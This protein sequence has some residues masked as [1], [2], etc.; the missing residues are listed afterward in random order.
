MI[1]S[2]FRPFLGAAGAALLF[3]TIAGCDSA[4]GPDTADPGINPDGRSSVT[5]QGGD[6]HQFIGGSFFATSADA[7]D[8]SPGVGLALY[9]VVAQDTSIVFFVSE[10]SNTR[11]SR[12]TY[13]IVLP[14]TTGSN[15]LASDEFVAFYV[16]ATSSAAAFAVG[17][18]G[19]LTITGSTEDQLRGTFTFGGEGFSTDDLIPTRLNGTGSF[20]AM[21]ATGDRLQELIETLGLD[22]F[23]DTNRLLHHA[24]EIRA[25]VAS[26]GSTPSRG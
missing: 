23:D 17:D 22:A 3:T 25:N 15:P 10:G 19:T 11:P 26:R 6:N 20:T 16:H 5:I 24:D 2:L 12:G 8:P 21:H 4:G 7:G 9:R 13:A 14:D 1:T 18:T